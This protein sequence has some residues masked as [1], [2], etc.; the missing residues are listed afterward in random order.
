[1]DTT[2]DIKVG[3]TVK[4]YQKG[5]SPFAGIVI[6][7][8]GG[9]SPSATFCVRAVLEG[10]GVEKIYPLHSPLINKIEILK[11]A[12][13]RRAKLYYLRKIVGK[14]KLKELKEGEKETHKKTRAKPKE[15]TRPKVKAVNPTSHKASRGKKTTRAKAKSRKGAKK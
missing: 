11:R 14:I 3:D 8:H 13:V 4:I 7:K 1:M 12:R 10:I 15:K 5:R 9:E 2:L 6:K